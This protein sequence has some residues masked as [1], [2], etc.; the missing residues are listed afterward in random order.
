MAREDSIRIRVSG[1][2]KRIIETASSRLNMSL[3]EY[4]R[5]LALPAATAVMT[6][7]ERTVEVAT[8][9]TSKGIL[10]RMQ[11]AEILKGLTK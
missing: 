8:N 9:S 10:N 5:F 6:G 3:S 4:I 2:E 11:E 1:E 7:D